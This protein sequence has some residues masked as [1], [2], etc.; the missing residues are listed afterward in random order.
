MRLGPFGRIS[1]CC[2]RQH[3]ASDRPAGVWKRQYRYVSLSSMGRVSRG[4]GFNADEPYAWITD[5][6]QESVR[7]WLV[8]DFASAHGFGCTGL[9]A[10][11]F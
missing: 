7:R 3:V 8:V 5:P 10:H 4:L 6:V 11:S 9:E 2:R 1:I